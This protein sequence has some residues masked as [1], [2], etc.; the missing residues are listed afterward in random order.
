MAPNLAVTALDGWLAGSFIGPAD[1]SWN[2]PALAPCGQPHRR[3]RLGTPTSSS[4]FLWHQAPR[5][6][7]TDAKAV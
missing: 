2:L 3:F 6:F 7:Y 5:E 1:S 4:V